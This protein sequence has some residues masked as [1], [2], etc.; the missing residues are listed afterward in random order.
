[1]PEVCEAFDEGGGATGRKL[2]PHTSAGVEGEGMRMTST[3]WVVVLCVLLALQALPLSDGGVTAVLSG[4][5]CA[6]LGIAI[7]YRVERIIKGDD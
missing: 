6:L 7:A 5:A 3:A 1:M 4:G 2:A